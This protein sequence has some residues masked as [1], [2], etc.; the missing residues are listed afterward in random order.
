MSNKVISIEFGLLKTRICE[1]DYKKKSPHIYHCISFDT[2]AGSY[3]DGYI[4]DKDALA[5]I[6]RDKIKESGIKSKKLIFSLMST[7]IANREVIIPL[8][9]KELIQEVVMADVEEYFPMDISEHAIT[10]SILEKLSI[11]DGKKLRLQ[12]LATPDNMVQGYYELAKLLGYE[13][14]TIDYMGNS[15]YQLVKN[16]ISEDVA[17]VLHINEKLTFLNVLE[18]GIL[19]LPRVINYGYLNIIDTLMNSNNAPISRNDAI[20][21]MN[22]SYSSEEAAITV[23]DDQEHLK[24]EILESLRYL[25]DNVARILDY[26]TRNDNKKI[27]VLYI[28]GQ[29]T[30][31][32]GLKAY[33]SQELGIEVIY[34]DKLDS[35]TIK[36]NS[37]IDKND[38]SRYISCVGAAIQPVNFIP[39]D[40]LEKSIRSSNIYAIIF[41]LTSGVIISI[42]LI[43][44]SYLSYKNER[45]TNNILKTEINNLSSINE[46]YNEHHTVSDMLK[47]VETIYD[48]TVSNNEYLNEL[49][50]TIEDNIP[51]GAIVD[52][53]NISSE[54]LSLSLVADSEV[55]VAKTLQ[56]LKSISGLTGVFTSSLNISENE[57]GLKTVSFVIETRYNPE[58][59][60][61]TE[62]DTTNIEQED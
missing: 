57:Y 7:K 34:L 48:L 8:V 37:N 31:W 46:I 1:V 29:V 32:I 52:S 35:I 47:Q 42:V 45:L 16:H 5:T 24:E 33:I 25:I 50:E 19:T 27:S 55:I 14:E 38:I 40:Y 17:M 6:I 21:L 3:Y 30:E 36:K 61:I 44:T 62:N 10:Y 12:V 11:E 53:I 49:L 39:K 4:K 59:F 54:G 2:P 13:V 15:A 22:S 58:G 20:D 41:T 26:S 60:I 56:Q 51:S 28:M 18:K 9:K 23:E 43:L